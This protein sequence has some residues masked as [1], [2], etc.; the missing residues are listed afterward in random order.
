[1]IIADTGFWLALANLRDRHHE[2]AK[3]AYRDLR[4][5][6]IT[7]WPVLT[8]TCHLLSARLGPDSA[9]RLVALGTKGAYQVSP[10]HPKHLVRVAA[11]MRKYRDLPIDLADASLVILAEELGSGR[12]LSTDARDFRTYRWKQRKPFTNLLE[13]D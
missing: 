13:L 2:A 6:L 12:I 8:E 5:P 7:T 3:R 9:E 11:L 1:V 10:M 4:E